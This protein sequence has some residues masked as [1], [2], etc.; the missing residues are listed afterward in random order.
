MTRTKSSRKPTVGTIRKSIAPMPDAW[1]CRKV[2]QVCDRPRPLLAMYL[3]TVDCDLDAELEKFAVDARRTPQPICQAH[4]PD[5][6]ADLLWYLQPTSPSARL[7]AP[8]QSEPRP[9]PPDN[10]LRLDNRHGVQH[11]RKQPIEPD[12]EQS[13]RHRQLRPRGYAL[14]Q[15][16][17]LV[18]QQH[19]LGFQSR[20][21]LEWRDQDVDEQDQE[22]NQPS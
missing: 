22:R 2:F 18:S 5:Q 15:H 7:P 3:A 12:E 21:C 20:P 14:T 10:R 1:L 17:Q 16:T 8:V 19:N 9:M 13:V 6:P 11:R 4:L